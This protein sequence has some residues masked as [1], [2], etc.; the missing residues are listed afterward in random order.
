VGP[1]QGPRGR[2]CGLG[3]GKLRLL[4]SS[5]A[6]RP[7]RAWAGHGGNRTL[8]LLRHNPSHRGRRAFRSS[9]GC[10]AKRGGDA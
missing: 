5:R 4:E 9:P 10:E 1:P 7:L 6:E 3:E 8:T 2:K